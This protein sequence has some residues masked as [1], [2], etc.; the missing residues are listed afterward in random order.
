M[1]VEES[2]DRRRFRDRTASYTW[3]VDDSAKWATGGVVG[4]VGDFRHE[5]WWVLPRCE[6]R[7]FTNVQ[8]ELFRGHRGR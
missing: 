6:A 1:T 7:L 5:F 4:S 3:R 8:G 2:G